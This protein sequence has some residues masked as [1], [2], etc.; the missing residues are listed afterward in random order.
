MNP[1]TSPFPEQDNP[2]PFDPDQK[3]LF[4]AVT[5]LQTLVGERGG[6]VVADTAE[7]TGPYRAMRAVG[8]VVVEY[9]E[10]TDEWGQD[11]TGTVKVLEGVTIENKDTVVIGIAKIKLTSGI[12]LLYL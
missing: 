3:L 5:L 4:K 7:H 12:A 2:L 1:P 11:E 9:V 6:I 8:E 10:P